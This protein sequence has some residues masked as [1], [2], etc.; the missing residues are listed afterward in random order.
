LA[1]VLLVGLFGL[2]GCTAGIN[3]VVGAVIALNMTT[4]ATPVVAPDATG[5]VYVAYQKNFEGLGHISYL[6]RLDA[7]GQ[8]LWPGA[9]AKIYL[10]KFPAGEHM[11]IPVGELVAA[12][13]GAILVWYSGSEVRAQKVDPSG[14]PLWGRDGVRVSWSPEPVR[15]G[16]GWLLR[17]VSD[18]A[19]GVVIASYANPLAG[20]NLD[21]FDAAGKSLWSGRQWFA[22]PSF[23]PSA[24]D[25]LDLAT[26]AHGNLFVL[27]DQDIFWGLQKVS[28]EGEV[29]WGPD[30]VV[31][32]PAMSGFSCGR[33][34]P[35]GAGGAIVLCSPQTGRADAF[36]K[37]QWSLVAQ[38]FDTLGKPRWP[39]SGL[40]VATSPEELYSRA[41]VSDGG[42]GVVVAW[43]SPD[44]E[45]YAQ[46][47]G[48]GGQPL[49]GA[50]G[51]KVVPKAPFFSLAPGDR[52]G[53]A[54]IVWKQ[55]ETIRRYTTIF[56]LRAQKLG[57]E[58][59]LAWG[60]GGTAFT[61]SEP[62]LASTPLIVADGEGGAWVAWMEGHGGGEA[63]IGSTYVQRI[64]A[65]G[66]PLWGASGVELTT[67]R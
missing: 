40:L 50:Q 6:Q 52:P 21:R 28:L 10:D 33:V 17:A 16:E 57:A 1:L 47:L 48:S 20:I 67:L 55:P 12:N 44:Q 37:K 58:G 65:D 7:G 61:A 8:P 23:P 29:Q 26:D 30:G 56:R 60:T 49:W 42:G 11:G 34:V 64:G 24:P 22:P 25:D 27:W 59:G 2:N 39:E 38:Y 31:P 15:A 3:P 45:I 32:F 13:G 41:F 14:N 53:E 19:D 66:R 9:G 4:V 51:V 63:Q 54:L 35:D 62:P 18:G 46:R 43:H 36:G 5:G